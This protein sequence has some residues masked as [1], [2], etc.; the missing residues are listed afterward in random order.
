MNVSQ[1]KIE[2]FRD[3]VK[4]IPI[5]DDKELFIMNSMNGMWILPEFLQQKRERELKDEADK[6]DKSDKPDKSDKNS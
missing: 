1:K 5:A 2:E 4:M 6:S 3:R